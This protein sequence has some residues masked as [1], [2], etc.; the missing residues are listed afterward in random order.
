MGRGGRGVGGRTR[1]I[2]GLMPLHMRLCDSVCHSAVLRRACHTILSLL[3]CEALS[4][5]VMNSIHEF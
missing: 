3:T 4:R 5:D 2:C 1:G